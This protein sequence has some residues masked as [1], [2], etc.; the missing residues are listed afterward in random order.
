MNA[1]ADNIRIVLEHDGGELQTFRTDSGG[2]TAGSNAIATV[3]TRSRARH[4][5]LDGMDMNA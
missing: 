4:H 5:R 1:P 3:P 2:R